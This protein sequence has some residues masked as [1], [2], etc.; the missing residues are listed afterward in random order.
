MGDGCGA[1]P[2]SVARAARAMTP[3]RLRTL[4]C[5][6]HGGS[7][8]TCTRGAREATVCRA[9]RAATAATRCCRHVSVGKHGAARR[10]ADARPPMAHTR[11]RCTDPVPFNLS[12]RAALVVRNSSHSRCSYAATVR[13]ADLTSCAAGVRCHDPAHGV[14]Q[15]K[16]PCLDGAAQLLLC[17]CV[18]ASLQAGH[19]P[20]AAHPRLALADL[21]MAPG[22]TRARRRRSRAQ[23][24]DAAA[25]LV[26]SE[27]GRDVEVMSCEG[28]ECGLPLSIP[29]AMIPLPAALELQA[30][31]QAFPPIPRLRSPCRPRTPHASSHLGAA[32]PRLEE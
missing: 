10:A 5:I 6:R 24:A 29:A 16:C 23:A 15:H 11:R 12:G 32:A 21:G 30:S 4:T 2:R 25:V 20:H 19:P 13:R 26:S 3:A 22:L 17:L 31:A 8:D 9:A 14:R 1:C 7:C 18:R 28:D 27:P